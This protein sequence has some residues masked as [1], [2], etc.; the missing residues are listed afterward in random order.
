V[1]RS[2]PSGKP[3]MI[4]SPSHAQLRLKRAAGRAKVEVGGPSEGSAIT[5]P[6]RQYET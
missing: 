1:V 5:F 3:R 2:V 6:R 4:E